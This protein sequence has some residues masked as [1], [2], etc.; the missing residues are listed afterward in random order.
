MEDYLKI[1]THSK[2]IG[3]GDD[4]G[5]K[6]YRGYMSVLYFSTS[7]VIYSLCKKLGEQYA[8]LQ[9]VA[10]YLRRDSYCKEQSVLYILISN[11]DKHIAG[12][13]PPLECLPNEDDFKQHVEY[14]KTDYNN[15]GMAFVAHNLL[16]TAVYLKF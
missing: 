11:I 12:A 3:R 1:Q 14:L 6:F 9:V 5:G 2:I 13:V 4:T 8:K 16:Y 15:T 7:Y 10:S